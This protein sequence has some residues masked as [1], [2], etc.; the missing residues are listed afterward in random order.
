MLRNI[1][2]QNFK[3]IKDM[4]EITMIPGKTRFYSDTHVKKIH[5]DDKLLKFSAIY[6][7]NSSGKSNF[8]EAI[9]ILSKIVKTGHVISYPTTPFFKSNREVIT[10]IELDISIKSKTFTYGVNLDLARGYIIEEY[11]IDISTEREKKIF[12]VKNAYNNILLKIESDLIDKKINLLFSNQIKPRDCFLTYLKTNAKLLDRDKIEDVNDVFEFMYKKL[13]VSCYNTIADQQYGLQ[14][15]DASQ[16]ELYE[17][18]LTGF[19][20][21]IKSITYTP[22]E[23]ETLRKEFKNISDSGF[24]M[25]V[26]DILKATKMNKDVV[27]KLTLNNNLYKIVDSGMDDNSFKI[28]LVKF[29]HYGGF[30]LSYLEESVGTRKLIN[31]INILADV[32]KND[33]TY[34]IDELGLSIHPMISRKIVNLFLEL[35]KKTNS[36]LIATSHDILLLDEE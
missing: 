23:L 17:E 25:L 26:T 11:L 1:R 2:I 36:Q 7:K 4:Q 34:L 8:I 6:G 28:T 15:L 16:Q 14:S 12:Y 5:D 22:I 33:S 29:E 35:A 21:G 3:S 27:V 32:Q 20:T 19:D 9:G 31:L 18:L 30:T 13:K 10:I 24:D